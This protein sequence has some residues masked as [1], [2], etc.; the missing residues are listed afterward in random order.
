MIREHDLVVLLQDL[1]EH[2]LR[3]GDVGVVVHVYAE[4][5]AFEVEFLTLAGETAAI[6]TLRAEQV[7]E[8]RP[9]E[10]PQARERLVA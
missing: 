8:V 9:D 5:A 1:P 4:R 3:A 10:M 6:E 2:L 7:R